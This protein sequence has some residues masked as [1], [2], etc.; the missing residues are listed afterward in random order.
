[1]TTETAADPADMYTVHDVFRREIGLEP[2][3]VR[4][5]PAGD[6][7]RAETIARHIDLVHGLLHHH[8]AGEDKHVW[9][10]LHERGTTDVDGI[11]HVMETQHQHI[12]KLNGEITLGLSEWR[13]SADQELG[14][15]L[16]GSLEA[17]SRVLREHLSLEEVEVLPLISKYLTATE[18]NEAVSDVAATVDPADL[19]LMFG[20]AL[21]EGDPAIIDDIVANMPSE[22]Q[23]VI[24]DLGRQAFAEHS[25]R[26]HGTTTP[27]RGRT[28]Y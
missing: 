17:L 3:L 10:K 14:A 18:W 23:P 5:V 19:A 4:A 22:A 2:D 28:S 26:I 6:V 8:H 13:A 11:V 1:M 7:A 25:Q 27:P 24:R 20:M 9:P 16:A 21:Y 12:E 15:S